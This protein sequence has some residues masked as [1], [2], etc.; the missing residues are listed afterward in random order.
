MH[1][2]LYICHSELGIANHFST[3]G[4]CFQSKVFS[5]TEINN[6]L[7]PWHQ[8]SG[9]SLNTRADACIIFSWNNMVRL[10]L[11]ACEIRAMLNCC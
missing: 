2:A 6:E 1:L 11:M 4:H 5:R 9:T 3:P 7:L 8:F 10:S